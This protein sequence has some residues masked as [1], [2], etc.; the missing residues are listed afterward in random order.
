MLEC[1]QAL[2][3]EFPVFQNKFDDNPCYGSGRLGFEEYF[4]HVTKF[5]RAIDHIMPQLKGIGMIKACD[6]SHPSTPTVINT[7]ILDSF[8]TYIEEQLSEGMGLDCLRFSEHQPRSARKAVVNV[9]SERFP[10]SSIN[11]EQVLILYGSS[12][13]WL[14]IVFRHCIVKSLQ[15]D[16]YHKR[17]VRQPIVLTPAGS[18]KC[19][20]YFPHASGGRLHYIPTQLSNNYKVTPAALENE[21]Q[22]IH[23]NG[24]E[25]VVCFVL[26]TPSALGQNYSRDD[27]AG[28]AEVLQNYPDI[29]WLQDWYN[30]GTEHGGQINPS[31]VENKKIATQG[32]TVAS[33]RRDWGGAAAYANVSA[34]HSG[35]LQFIKEISK[36]CSET[37]FYTHPPFSKLQGFITSLIAEEMQSSEFASDNQRYFKQQ[38]AIYSNELKST[39]QWLNQALQT[40]NVDYIFT[41]SAE[42][43]QFGFLFFNQEITKKAGVRNGTEMAELMCLYGKC[44]VMPTL[45]APMGIGYDPVGIR[46]NICMSN[47]AQKNH[48]IIRET[49]ARI[50]QLI[51]AIEQDNLQYALFDSLI[52]RLNSGEQIASQELDAFTLTLPLRSSLCHEHKRFMEVCTD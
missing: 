52:K 9:L 33:F 48:E 24:H 19:G 11:E 2:Y 46:M 49:L 27:L 38:F 29:F 8:K 6:V 13:Q 35:N 51:L 10:Q 20:G 7:K 3:K 45:L 16:F 12:T 26:E 47:E 23:Q 4:L 31:L 34:L 37:Y 5:R 42:A 43:G 15:D 39:N 21:I 18:F 30:L 50:A 22:L 44:R 17:Q 28:F 1:R 36:Q 14:D 41:I 40:D 32:C 25:K